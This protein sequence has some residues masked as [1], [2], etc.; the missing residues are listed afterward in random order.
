MMTFPETRP[1]HDASFTVAKGEYVEARLQA[2]RLSQ[3][4]SSEK[5]DQID[6]LFQVAPGQQ[7]IIARDDAAGI[8]G[9]PGDVGGQIVW[10]TGSLNGGGAAISRAMKASRSSAGDPFKVCRAIAWTV[11]SRF[12]MRCL[13]SPTSSCW[14]C[15]PWSRPAPPHPP[16]LRA[17]LRL[18]RSD[19]GSSHRRHHRR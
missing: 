7:A 11:A 6:L 14:R 1:N 4:K 12:L 15:C 19:Q 8:K 17:H 18:P 16:Q 10:F 9:G 3:S 2:I 5:P 13:T